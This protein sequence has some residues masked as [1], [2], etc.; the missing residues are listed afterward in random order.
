MPDTARKL[1]RRRAETRSRLVNA[2]FQVFAEKG[3]ARV[4]V[5]DVCAAAGYTH[6]AFYSQFRNLEELFYTIYN[7][8][9][10]WI[11]DQVR[12]CPLAN[13]P[14]LVDRIVDAV[15][16]DREWLLIKLDFV[17]HAARNPDLAERWWA[18]REQ[19]RT[20]F[21]EWLIAGDV[22]FSQGAKD[23]AGAARAL[24]T[25]Y[26]GFCLDLLATNDTAGARATFTRFIDAVIHTG[27][28]STITQ[29]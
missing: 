6:G 24:L 3:F 11:V 23:A 14:E 27:A 10:A 7:V 21:E 20:V 5:E 29:D 22:E 26:D 12:A 13:L 28:R 15:S 16:R 1:T 2:A 19:L 17:L 8:R 4:R 18:H 9:T 25:A